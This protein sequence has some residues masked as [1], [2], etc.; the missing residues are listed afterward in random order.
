M[1]VILDN[2]YL[3]MFGFGAGMTSDRF[4]DSALDPEDLDDDSAQQFP[5][6]MKR[7]RMSS[8]SCDDTDL[9]ALSCEVSYP[10]STSPAPKHKQIV[11]TIW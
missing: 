10:E 5:P 7:Q 1:L 6:W 2:K 9:A 11:E 4:G 3:P 8:T